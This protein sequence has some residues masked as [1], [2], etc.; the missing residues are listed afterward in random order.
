MQDPRQRIGGEIS[1]EKSYGA[2]WWKWR[3]W[4]EMLATGRFIN[5]VEITKGD[6]LEEVLLD[7]KV[8]GARQRKDHGNNFDLFTL[9][10]CIGC[11][12]DE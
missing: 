4:D 10:S 8:E 5:I 11:C 2:N 12:I 6:G 7:E 9:I 1:S 3:F